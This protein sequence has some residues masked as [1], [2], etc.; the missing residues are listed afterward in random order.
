[1]NAQTVRSRAIAKQDE[2]I[3][4]N[5]AKIEADRKSVV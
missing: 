2:Q 1:M 3:A 5:V 4:S